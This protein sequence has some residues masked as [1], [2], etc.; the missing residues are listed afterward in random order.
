[1]VN[2]HTMSVTD[3]LQELKASLEELNEPLAAIL[4]NAQAAQRFL[5]QE[6]P[7]LDEIRE[8]LADIVED[9]RRASEMIRRLRNLLK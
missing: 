3:D 2:L 1:M 6:Q 9:D 5:E 4:S 8:I 7:D